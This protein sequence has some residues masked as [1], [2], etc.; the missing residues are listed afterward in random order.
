[1]NYAKAE[2]EKAYYSVF[3]ANGKYLDTYACGSPMIEEI[4][5]NLYRLR[6]N[7]VP[8]DEFKPYFA[9][10]LIIAFDNVIGG[11]YNTLVNSAESIVTKGLEKVSEDWIYHTLE[12]QKEIH[13]LLVEARIHF[14]VYNTINKWN[15]EKKEE[16][17]DV[18]DNFGRVIDGNN[19]Y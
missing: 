10:N 3:N 12:N 13:R 16:N 5:N 15:E 4:L 11:A 7:L 17:K 9:S 6:W 2:L 18:V 19:M 14:T 8:D 1:M